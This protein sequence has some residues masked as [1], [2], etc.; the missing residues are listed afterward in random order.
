VNQFLLS[1]DYRR[2]TKHSNDQHTG[3]ICAPYGMQ[4]QFSDSISTKQT[5]YQADADI[6][7]GWRESASV[8]EFWSQV[9]I[10]KAGLAGS[11]LSH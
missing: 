2:S 4:V 8:D 9:A 3:R 1:V 7:L 6:S 10:Q 5:L 11:M